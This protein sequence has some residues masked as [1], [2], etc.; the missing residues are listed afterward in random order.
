MDQNSLV[1]DHILF[2]LSF[3]KRFDYSIAYFCYCVV[4]VFASL[5]AS[6]G[7]AVWK[8]N[9]RHFGVSGLYLNA[10]EFVRVV[11]SL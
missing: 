2:P 3:M 8:C 11:F 9:Y 10:R 4:C 7:N 1:S 5:N 6:Q